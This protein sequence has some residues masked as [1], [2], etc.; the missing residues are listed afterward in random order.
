MTPEHTSSPT[1]AREARPVSGAPGQKARAPSPRLGRLLLLGVFTGATLLAFAL[2][3]ATE[4]NTLTPTQRQAREQIRRLEGFFKAH[5]RLMGFFPTQEQGFTPLID[6]K[7]LEGPPIDPWGNPYVYRMS[8][9]T[10]AVLSLGSDGQ[11]GGTGDAADL[12]SGGIV[13]Q[14]VQP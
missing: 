2:V 11:P 8:G 13:A 6:S 3:W 4:D 1:S 12:F 9:K 7:V 14:G 5:H 10:G